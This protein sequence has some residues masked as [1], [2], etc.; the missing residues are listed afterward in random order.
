MTLMEV[1]FSN[2]FVRTSNFKFQILKWEF[3]DNLVN[4]DNSAFDI[5]DMS[6]V[7]FSF[8]ENSRRYK[9]AQ[10]MHCLEKEKFAQE[11]NAIP[12]SI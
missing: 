8:S 6:F 11:H 2:Y 9:F 5:F 1:P 12:F 7:L 3:V 4:I 10:I